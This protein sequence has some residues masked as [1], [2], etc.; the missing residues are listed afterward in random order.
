MLKSE[1]LTILM[2]KG[3][4][5]VFEG[6][7]YVAWL[8]VPLIEREHSRKLIV[9]K[10]NSKPGGYKS[11]HKYIIYRSPPR[12]PTRKTNKKDLYSRTNRG[13]S[14]NN[15]QNR[16]LQKHQTTLICIIKIEITNFTHMHMCIFSL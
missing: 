13:D 1:V 4:L 12:A 10:N 7:D 6:I 3:T 9:N 2:C 15:L 5:Y 14:K 16:T 8:S 11:A